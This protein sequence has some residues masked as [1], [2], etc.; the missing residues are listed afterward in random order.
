M[1]T[2]LAGTGSR[3]S[4]VE[5]ANA[6]MYAMY[7]GIWGSLVVIVGYREHHI[8]MELCE[9]SDVPI[10]GFVS[11]RITGVLALH[12]NGPN[13]LPVGHSFGDDEVEPAVAMWKIDVPSGISELPGYVKLGPVISN[14]HTSMCA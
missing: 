11:L 14:L 4:A 5:R 8:R 6:G 2:W 9:P 12:L 10:Q 1:N 13:D 3:A 7:A